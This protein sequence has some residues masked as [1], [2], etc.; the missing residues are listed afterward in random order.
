ML[1]RQLFE[2]DVQV[3]M[4]LDGLV[5]LVVKWIQTVK[6]CKVKHE[7][8]LKR[9]CKAWNGPGDLCNEIHMKLCGGEP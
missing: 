9:Y 6:I 4:G 3:L 1:L 7:K 5:F 8:E 2:W